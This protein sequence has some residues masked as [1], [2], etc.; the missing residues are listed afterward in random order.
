MAVPIFIRTVRIYI[1]HYMYNMYVYTVI[2]TPSTR[3]NRSIKVF[4]VMT[5]YLNLISYSKIL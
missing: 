2:T 1:L 4:P 5:T 3:K